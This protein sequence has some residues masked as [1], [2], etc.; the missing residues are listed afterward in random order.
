MESQS[1]STG[2]SNPFKVAKKYFVKNEIIT[3]GA[4][5]LPDKRYFRRLTGFLSLLSSL[6]VLPAWANNNN[7]TSDVTLPKIIEEARKTGKVPAVYFWAE[8]CS[9]C[10]QIE[11]NMKR[12][13]ELLR[14]Q[15]DEIHFVKVN[16]DTESGERLKAFL[17]ASYLPMMIL[18]NDDGSERG[19]I[20]S[21]GVFNMTDASQLAKRLK[22]MAGSGDPLRKLERR[23]NNGG[24][25]GAELAFRI[26]QEYILRD[27]ARL[28]E[29]WA[30]RGL[31]EKTGGKKD[32]HAHIL[33]ALAAHFQ[34]KPETFP[35]AHATYDR[36][37]SRPGFDDKFYIF[38]FSEKAKM[39]F[40]QGEKEKGKQALQRMLEV[41]PGSLPA[42]KEFIYL[43]SKNS[44]LTNLAIA[45]AREV[46]AAEDNP[47]V[48]EWLDHLSAVSP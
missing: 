1:I 18:F 12:D 22:E 9:Y 36:L 41:S 42:K 17:K 43:C 19:G 46:L 48:R 32:T 3:Y 6:W 16:V 39:Y 8:W 7:T 11:D 4:M 44:V 47:K 24:E 40:R 25:R 21:D 35:R 5:D 45:T 10:L 23:W 33:Y 28:A 29:E 31:A 26:M 38:S 13:K 34:K 14:L 2:L 15:K 37:I 30:S 20:V 27:E